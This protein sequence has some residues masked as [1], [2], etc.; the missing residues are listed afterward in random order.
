[1]DGSGFGDT[2][3]ESEIS[4]QQDQT[5]RLVGAMMRVTGLSASALAR[6]AGLTPSTVNRFMHQT[7]RHTLSQRTLLALMIVTFDRLKERPLAAF[8]SSAIAELA[9]AIPVF[10]RALAGHDFANRTVIEAIKAGDAPSAQAKTDTD[11]AVV[12][13][14]AAGIDVRAGD[15]RGAVLKTPR[16]PFLAADERAFAV[17]MPDA[18]MSPRFEAGDLLYVSPARPA[19]ETGADVIVILPT[20]R[21]LIGRVGGGHAIAPLADDWTFKPEHAAAIYRI[22]GSHRP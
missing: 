18:S 10:E 16:P 13:I 22:V 20:A 15:F 2:D 11:I 19:L 9:K 17:L 21:F 8:E 4:A 5:R 3:L 6:A 14:G 1:M 12:T 7:V